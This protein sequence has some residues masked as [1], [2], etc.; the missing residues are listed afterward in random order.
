MSRPWDI[1]RLL[2]NGD[3]SVGSFSVTGATYHYDAINDGTDGSHDSNTTCVS[4]TGTGSEQYSIETLSGPPSTATGILTVKVCAAATWIPSVVRVGI[5]IGGTTYWSSDLTT[6]T[7]SYAWYSYTWHLNPATNKFFVPSDFSGLKVNLYMSCGGKETCKATALYLEYAYNKSTVQIVDYECTGST[8]TS[9]LTIDTP[10]CQPGD[11]LLA[12]THSD[13]STTITPPNGFSHFKTSTNRKIATYIRVADGSESSSY[14]FT[15]SSSILTRVFLVSIRGLYNDSPSTAEAVDTYR[16]G[17]F[18]V[19][20]PIA[21]HLI[22]ARCNSSID[23]TTRYVELLETSYSGVYFSV[24]LAYY[25]AGSVSS[26]N[27]DTDVLAL[28]DTTGLCPV[29][30]YYAVCPGSG[31]T[32]DKKTGSPTITISGGVATLSV[33]QTGNIGQGFCVDYDTD[34][35]KAY[36]SLVNS[37]TSFDVVTATGGVPSNCSGLTVNSISAPFNSLSAAE[38]GASGSS[39][40]NTS[41]LTSGNYV[42]NIVCYAGASADTT[43]LEINGYTTSSSYYMHIYAANGGS[44]SL[45]GN[46]HAGVWDTSKYLLSADGDG[47]SVLR[48]N[49]QYVRI[50]GLQVEG[51]ED[52]YNTSVIDISQPDPAGLIDSVLVKNHTSNTTMRGSGGGIRCNYVTDP[53]TNT[54][55]IQ[56]CV[57]YGAGSQYDPGICIYDFSTFDIYNCTIQNCGDGICNFYGTV[58]VVNCAIFN[59]NDDFYND[60]G[61]LNV[62]YTASDDNDISGTGNFQIGTWSV[63]FTDYANGDV[64]LKNFTGTGALI[65]AGTTI[66]GMEAVD[67]IGTSRPQG[68]AWD[69][70][71]FEYVVSGGSSLFG[72]IAGIDESSV[73]KIAGVEVSSISKIGGIE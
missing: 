29:N 33:A 27:V 30:V 14:T 3:D 48:I 46:R 11:I 24:Q 19:T 5:T 28:M 26:F 1:A 49:D 13:S 56:N 18:T 45:R 53:S 62:S 64:S 32:S 47:D 25:S 65:N 63:I 51:L 23:T 54:F 10:S 70:G 61:T 36:I 12:V 67:I 35:K 34:N 15:Y 21:P 52:T 6:T 41:D 31:G 4:I 44:Q 22:V 38:S 9:V 42:L 72:K 68:S 55:T 73:S 58:N 50:T 43:A 2:P 20:Q 60:S 40:L 37:A 69:I 17:A 57:I 59:N 7:T 39:Y 66:S 8:S 71:A 16:V